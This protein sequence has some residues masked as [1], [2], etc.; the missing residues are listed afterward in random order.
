MHGGTALA[1]V[2][3]A[4]ALGCGKVVCLSEL[5]C[6][7]SQAEADRLNARSA[8]N[9]YAACRVADANT[10]VSPDATPDDAATADVVI[11]STS[12]QAGSTGTGPCSI[13]TGACRDCMLAECNLPQQEAASPLTTEFDQQ[14][15][16]YCVCQQQESDSGG[17][18]GTYATSIAN[19][20]EQ[21]SAYWGAAFPT[22]LQQACTAQCLQAP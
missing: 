11:D 15:Y 22:C 20:A 17:N 19:C 2:V 14:W 13:N 7:S 6:V 5:I 16:L 21:H 10:D 18:G 12:G 3:V 9:N 4:T 8:C 1:A